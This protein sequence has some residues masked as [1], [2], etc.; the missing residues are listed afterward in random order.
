VHKSKDSRKAIA[1]LA[2]LVSWEILKERNAY[3]FH[4]PSI[5]FTVLVQKS[6]RR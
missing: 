5:T 2:M 3:V 4:N 1:I 6:K